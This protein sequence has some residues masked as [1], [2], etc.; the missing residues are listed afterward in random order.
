MTKGKKW[1]IIAILLAVFLIG[2]GV[3]T[4]I[5]FW[6]ILFPEKTYTVQGIVVVN[7]E[8]VEG[9][10]VSSNVGDTTTDAEGKYSFSGLKDP[11]TVYVGNDEYYFGL[12]EKTF[13]DEAT[14]NI[15]GR[16][17]REVT[18]SIV[19]GGNMIPFATVK[20][21]AENGT[22]ETISDANGNFS[23]PKVIGEVKI[24]AEKNGMQM[25]EKVLGDDEVQAEL[26]ALT[27]IA[28]TF[29]FD[30]GLGF[31]G[32]TDVKVEYC[33]VKYDLESALFSIGSVSFGEE[34][35]ISSNNYLLN[36]T[37]V[38][39]D[40]ENATV[41][42]QGKRI[43]DISGKIVSGDTPIAN[44]KILVDGKETT[45]TDAN[46]N[47]LI[48]DVTGAHTVSYVKK[49]F[50]TGEQQVNYL[51]TEAN[52]EILK[53]VS[54]KVLFENGILR[55]VKVFTASTESVTDASGNYELNC[56]LGETIAFS[57]DGYKLEGGATVN[58]ATSSVN[59]TA[60]KYYSLTV[61][62]LRKGQAVDATI[63]VGGVE[64]TLTNGR[65]TI[66]NLLGAKSF[67]IQKDGFVFEAP[68]TVDRF[69][70]SITLEAL[71]YFN[72][73]GTVMSGNI[74]LSGKVYVNGVLNKEFTSGTFTIENILESA[75]IA[76]RCDGYDGFSQT[77]SIEEPT[78]NADLTYSVTFKAMTGSFAVS[79]W[80][81]RQ[82]AQPSETVAEAKTISGLK[83]EN[84]FYFEKDYHNTKQV[85]VNKG[86]EVVFETEYNVRISVTQKDLPVSGWK[87][88]L[89]NAETEDLTEHITDANGLCIFENLVGEYVIFTESKN[90]VVFRPES[91]DLTSGG[92]YVFS[93]NGYSFG[94]RITC[95]GQG[96][97]GAKVM[98][99]SKIEYT[100]RNGYY[101]FDMLPD[102]CTLT[103][104][105]DGYVFGAGINVDKTYSDRT[106]V[107]FEGTYSVIGKVLCGGN[108]LEGVRVTLGAITVTTDANGE[109]VISGINTVNETLQLSKDGFIMD[110]YQV[111]G[112]MQIETI[113]YV[114]VTLNVLCGGINVEGVETK[115]NGKT[116]GANY[117]F[118][119]GEVV[120]FHKAGYEFNSITIERAGTFDIEGT[121]TITGKVVNGSVGMSGAV[122]ILNGSQEI[123]CNDDGTFAISGL[124]GANDI[125]ARCGGFE[126]GTV[127]VSGP[128][129]VTIGA[130]YSAT[131]IVRS[132]AQNLS[133]VLVRVG[134]KAGTT[135]SDGKVTFAGLMAT[136]DVTCSKEGYEI[137][138]TSDVIEGAGEYIFNATYSVSGK[139]LCDGLGLEGA[140][141]KV[142]EREV[143]TNSNGEFTVN[144][145]EGENNLFTIT[146]VGGAGEEYGTCQFTVSAPTENKEV[147]ITYS[148][149]VN[150]IFSGLTDYRGITV[151]YLDTDKITSSNTLSIAGLSGSVTF[152]FAKD[153]C[154]FTPASQTVTGPSTLTVNVVQYY[155]ITGYVKTSSGLPVVGYTV[156]APGK[157]AVVT[158]S[159]GYFSF[160]NLKGQIALN[161]K[162][163]FEKQ[164][165]STTF[166]SDLCLQTK[167]VTGAGVHNI[168]ISDSDY[169]KGLFINGIY[170]LYR[171]KSYEIV[172]RGKVA[173]KSMGVT[174][175]TDSAVV[176]RKDTKGN[177]VSENINYGS[178]VLG[179]DP[180]VATLSFYNKD[181]GT[182]KYKRLKDGDKN[183]TINSSLVGNYG[184]QSW[185]TCSRSEYEN[186]LGTTVTGPFA[187]NINAS[188]VTDC[189]I[190][191]SGDIYTITLNLKP[192]DQASYAKQ[193][194][195]LAGAETGSCSFDTINLTVTLSKTGFI[196]TV[197]A[198][199]EYSIKVGSF[200][201][202]TTTD[203]T[204][205]VNMPSLTFT[206]GNLDVDN[207]L[208][209][210]I[211]K[212]VN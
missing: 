129:S 158:D 210:A 163:D 190:S 191:K 106:D 185:T 47:Y 73:D 12:K 92:E 29:E 97:Y 194:E 69:N 26:N 137:T 143:T 8:P 116:V 45:T 120:T 199:E 132:G 172:G 212:E 37:K 160:N 14:Y 59:A 155:D 1:S 76:V 89:I 147:S 95:G 200:S 53:K 46:G 162:F 165:A 180:S 134:N 57:L 145:L 119:L 58:D 27:S 50:T 117:K 173:G 174:K 23:V 164:D 55:G 182:V 195:V 86:G 123:P 127:T 111:N 99:G 152:M 156:T 67:Q 48:E 161:G 118:S 16:A 128:K 148:Y 18:G 34:I 5:F 154:E 189:A 94:G 105:K 13:I 196:S 63:T 125:T 204:F 110:S 28:L 77:V 35:K 68:E 141:V 122:A 177:I 40:K 131:I 183:G 181:A 149:S 124:S 100:D 85:T 79:Q 88:Y 159:N 41:S 115:V 101:Y 138:G 62:A 80:Q 133:G 104:S 71:Q 198:H 9:F 15:A 166:D 108:P 7:G 10:T 56:K 36:Q 84:T 113:A 44:A 78:F 91:Y 126:F 25:F 4:Y 32:D 121:Y 206:I 176:K 39:V 11:I 135:D 2:A 20:I 49:G 114:D 153:R 146:K 193:T 140:T 75:E 205:T 142:G 83:G 144:G 201:A 93:D 188:T 187:Y 130:T 102:A 61:S 19:S 211:K 171:G 24:S 72:V 151:A 197:V 192:K 82:G 31:L 52:F 30:D 203:T 112:F 21:V 17:Y 109:Y 150:I 208:S 136:N 90:G 54:G 139:V 170:N 209:A 178:Q 43:Y 157:T 179:I 103:V 51:N 22:Y 168:I 98:A 74:P 33:G 70:A 107:D 96:I 6:D 64:Y 38:I 202:A 42:I 65:I 66:D 81:L 3:V 175:N 186:M 207:N 167:S 184:G 169:A 60:Q 87:V